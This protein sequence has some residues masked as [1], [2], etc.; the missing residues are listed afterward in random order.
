M[1]FPLVSK[2]NC[3]LNVETNDKKLLKLLLRNFILISTLEIINRNVDDFLKKITKKHQKDLYSSDIDMINKIINE[4]TS[5]ISNYKSN[6]EGTMHNI[7]ES[8]SEK[9]NQVESIKETLKKSLT[10]M[11]FTNVTDN[12]L[13]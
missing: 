1:R 3:N 5:Q 13:E 9:L 12:D 11:Y 4:T 2:K 7:N 8:I 10:K 6:V